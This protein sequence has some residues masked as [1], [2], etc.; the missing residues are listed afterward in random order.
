ML[1]GVAPLTISNQGRQKEFF[2]EV[3]NFLGPILGFLGNTFCTIILYQSITLKCT[4]HS[5]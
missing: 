4:W 2:L 1:S 3:I 5:G